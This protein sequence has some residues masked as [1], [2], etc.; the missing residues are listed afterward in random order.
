M[1]KRLLHLLETKVDNFRFAAQRRSGRR[2]PFQIKCY[3]G[4][5]DD[6]VLR[7][8]GRVLACKD[9]PE[10]N[11]SDRRWRNFLNMSRQWFTDEVPDARL[12]ARFRGREFEIQADDEGYFKAEIEVTEP[13]SGRPSWLEVDLTLNDPSTIGDEAHAQATACIDAVP[14]SC[15]TYPARRVP[16]S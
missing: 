4:Y 10:S 6:R 16:R 5:G 2:R 14:T 13:L 11:A 7:I 9:R 12:K 3:N 8:G 1:L 15:C